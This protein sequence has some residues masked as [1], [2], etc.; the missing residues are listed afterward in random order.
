MPTCGCARQLLCWRTRH[1]SGILHWGLWKLSTSARRWGC[2]SPISADWPKDV[3]SLDPSRRPEAAK[4][5]EHEAAKK[6]EHATVLNGHQHL[7][8]TLFFLWKLHSFFEQ[9]KYWSRRILSIVQPENNGIT[10]IHVIRLLQV[11]AQEV[12]TIPSTGQLCWLCSINLIR[13][14]CKLHLLNFSGQLCWLLTNL[15]FKLCWFHSQRWVDSTR[16]F[17]IVS[18][19]G[20]HEHLVGTEDFAQDSNVTS[21]QQSLI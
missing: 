14:N 1:S 7:N 11:L 10:F 4:K 8:Y 3:H 17:V 13:I 15:L 2:D 12:S 9:Y 16:L 21:S 5:W 6:W 18:P 20:F 19:L